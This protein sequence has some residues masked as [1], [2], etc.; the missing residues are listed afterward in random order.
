LRVEWDE[1][2]LGIKARQVV[3]QLWEG[4]PRIAVGSNYGR[5]QGF[6]F[7]AFMNAPGDEKIAARRAR[8]VFEAARKG[9]A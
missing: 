6:Q 5:D 2:A 8:E 7:C 3:R 1:G 9:T 4:E